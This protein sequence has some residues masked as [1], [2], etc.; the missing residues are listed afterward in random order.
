MTENLV[1]IKDG[2]QTEALIALHGASKAQGMGVLHDTG[3]PLSVEAAREYLKAG[4]TGVTYVDYC[5]GR[6]IKVNFTTCN[7]DLRNFDN[8]LGLGA[9]RRALVQAGL[10]DDDRTEAMDALVLGFSPR[11]ETLKKISNEAMKL[12]IDR[13]DEEF[14][15]GGNLCAE[16]LLQLGFCCE[17]LKRKL[18]RE[19][20]DLVK[21]G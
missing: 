1:V 17:Q 11:A 9:G 6:V 2:T 3:E 14:N 4:P 7:L 20:D 15:C 8:D 16:D 12:L 18:M 5:Q 21:K 13:F 10:L 19:V